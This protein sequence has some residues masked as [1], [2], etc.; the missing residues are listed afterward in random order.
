MNP[1]VMKGD[2][3]VSWNEYYE[4]HEPKRGDIAIFKLPTDMEI[5]YIKRLVGLPGDRIQ[6]RDG[7]LQINGTPIERELVAERQVPGFSG[8]L[9]NVAEYIETLPGGARY[10][11]WEE[12]DQAYHDNTPEYQVPP[13]HYFALADNRDQSVDSRAMEVVGFIPRENLRDFPTFIFWSSDRSRIGT[14][15]QPLP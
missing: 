3:V 6:M 5:D 8:E 13:E 14:A 10:S 9:Q 2:Y 12:S 7:I 11:I 1:T 15:V 4:A